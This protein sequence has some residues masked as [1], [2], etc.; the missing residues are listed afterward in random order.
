MSEQTTE[1]W[2]DRQRFAWG[3]LLGGFAV[4]L[5]LTISIPVSVSAYLQNATELLTVVVA[6]NQGTV[7]IDNESGGRRALLEGE[8][9]LTVEPGESLLTGNNATGLLSFSPPDS[10]LLLARFQ[11]YS[12]T[13]LRLQQADAPQFAVS[14]Q[15]YAIAVE[16]DTGR[17]R[18]SVPKQET[19]QPVIIL[20]TPQGSIN[21]T[22]PGQYA[23]IVSNEETQVTVQDG[24]AL[25]FGS[26]GS[27]TLTI[28]ANERAAIPNGLPPI[29]PLETER[30]LVR[31]SNFSST[32]D[33]WNIL[34][35]QV[36]RVDQPAGQVRILES[37]ESR[38]NI[39]RLGIGH[40]DVQIRQSVNQNVSEL[41]SLRMLV[42]FRIL[43]QSLA[44]CGIEGS[45]CPLFVRLNY[46]DESGVSNTWQQGFYAFGDVNPG[47]NPDSC[48]RCAVIQSTHERV[49]LGQDYFYD[50]DIREELARQGR[51]PPQFIESVILVISGHSFEVEIMDVALLAEE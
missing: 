27:E 31:N 44:V 17:L 30:N 6:A 21:V 38:L 2:L 29:G 8:T 36:E 34:A 1:R 51:V 26:T 19:R 33:F 35:W 28:I 42:T 40:A 10:E 3:I 43:N 47:Q 11:I 7:G 48:V 4:C 14:D 24:S 9:G 23:V 32:T 20:N 49:S 16:L 5:L 41:T 18:L 46:I 25:I 39:A 12:N 37:G 22:D 13:D 45:E 15:N 50:V